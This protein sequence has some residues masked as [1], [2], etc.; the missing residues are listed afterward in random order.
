MRASLFFGLLSLLLLSGCANYQLGTGGKVSF[1]TLYVAPVVNESN[2]PQAVAIVSTQLR[3]AFLHDPRII[4]VNSPEEADAT[5]TVRLLKYGRIGKT[6]RRD[7]TGL[8]RNFDVTLEAE[9]TLRDNR[10]NR[11]LFE[12]RKA[13]ATRETF[14]D[15]GQLQAEFNNVPLLG[16][17]LAKN[18]RSATLD[19]W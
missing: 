9:T 15:S 7:D 3:E 12:N 6:G 16:E 14:G 4:L 11:F 2:L 19:T 13:A 10:D 18:I 17:I 5:L 8:S 1:R